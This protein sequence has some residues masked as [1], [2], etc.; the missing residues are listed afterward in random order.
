MR[1]K[2]IDREIRHGLQDALEHYVGEE[3]DKCLVHPRVPVQLSFEF[4]RTGVRGKQE[5]GE[6]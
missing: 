1:A 3:G 2:E 5:R 6:P 4:M